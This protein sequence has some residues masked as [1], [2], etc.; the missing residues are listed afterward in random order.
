MKKTNFKFFPLFM[1]G[2]GY[3][4]I[5]KNFQNTLHHTNIFELEL[6]PMLLWSSFP[7]SL[8]FN[9]SIDRPLDQHMLYIM[10]NSKM[11]VTSTRIFTG[12]SIK[13]ARKS[14]TTK[15]IQACKKKKN[16]STYEQQSRGCFCIATWLEVVQLLGLLA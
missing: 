14:N 1:K 2:F 7:S 16:T 15:G 5:H 4:N 11:A 12:R 13:L 6:I 10:Y 8:I 9:T 3:N